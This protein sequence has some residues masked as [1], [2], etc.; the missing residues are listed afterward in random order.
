MK[1]LGEKGER[2]QDNP[3]S[4]NPYLDGSLWIAA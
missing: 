2:I 3:D 1:E 4:Q